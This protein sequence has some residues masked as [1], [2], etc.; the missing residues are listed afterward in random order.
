VRVMFN[1]DEQ[2]VRDSSAE[3]QVQVQ[4]GVRVC[5][6]TDVQTGGTWIGTNEFGMMAAI[7]NLNPWVR[8]ASHE[9][10]V[11]SRSTVVPAALVR[12]D[13]IAAVEAV[14]AIVQP[15]MAGFRVWLCDGHEHVIG[16]FDGTSL[17]WHERKVLAERVML[18]SSGLGDHVVQGVRQDKFVRQLGGVNEDESSRV[19]LQERFHTWHD[20][21]D[22]ARSVLMSR[23]DARTVSITTIERDLQTTRV[24]YQAV[25]KDLGLGPSADCVL[26]IAPNLATARVAGRIAKHGRALR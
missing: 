5:M 12:A 10:A 23:A 13:L 21:Q 15:N 19:V 11:A 18:T 4:Q 26:E 16:V 17:V 8:T 24:R 9:R 1:R 2:H 6:P 14:S 25:A 3:P 22:G 7:L 20:P